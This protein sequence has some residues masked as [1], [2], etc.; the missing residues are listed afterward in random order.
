[1]INARG[2]E[3]LEARGLDVDGAI[4]FGLYTTCRPGGDAST[5]T[6]APTADWIA[7]PFCV[8]GEVVN[9]KFRR[10]S[11][12]GFAQVKDGKQV[13]W[14]RDVLRDPALEKYPLVIT[15]GE[16][17][18]LAAIQAGYP[19][20][21]SV[22]GGAPAEAGTKRHTYIDEAWNDLRDV[23][24]IVLATDSDEPG[25]NLRDD[26]IARFGKPRCKTIRYPKGCKDLGDALRLYGVKGVQAALNT[27]QPVPMN[28]LVQLNQIPEKPPLNPTKIDGLGPDFHRHIGICPGHLS[29]WTGRANRGKTSLLRAVC[30]SLAK[31]K[32]WRIAVGSFEDDIRQTWLPAMLRVQHG[33]WPHSP[34][35]REAGLA[36]IEDTYR[37]ILPPETEQLT[38]PYTLELMEAAVI[39][40]GCNLILIDPWTE[41][42][43][44]LQAGVSETDAV[45]TYLSA[46]RHFARRF[47]CHVAIIAH[48]RKPPDFG[49]TRRLPD[50]YDISGS[51]HF[52]NKCD[53]GVTV[54]ADPDIDR[55]TVVRVW[56]SRFKEEMGPTGDFHLVYDTSTRRF[57]PIDRAEVERWR[58]R[59]VA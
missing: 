57:S 29:I 10:L 45:K 35:D 28:A 23:R 34:E 2:V 12:K 31:E 11:E 38:V 37:F 32:G 4:R 47:H 58:E 8:D 5:A 46:F 16:M 7:I 24:E 50:G 39:R 55:L 19:R 9:T 14:N 20:T 59:S 18:A 52:F 3:W 42:D 17:D 44:E 25:C 49:G 15:E 21:V 43:L 6:D 26:L 54:E 56:K 48:P 51:A 13:L 53:L 27:A 40:H 1:M 33:G 30:W 36:W 41:L 22:P